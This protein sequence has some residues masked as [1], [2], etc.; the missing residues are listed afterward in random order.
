MIRVLYAD[1]EP[2]LLE[3]TRL[4]LERTGEFSVDAVESAAEGLQRLKTGQYD[5][6]LSDYQMPG[7]DGIRFLKQIRADGNTIPFIVFTGRGREDVVIDAI[8]SGA[9]SYIQK[10]G[11]P[12][13]QFAELAHKI[14]Q[15]VRRYQAERKV[16]EGAARFQA[17]FE[18]IWDIIQIFGRDGR[19]LYNSPSIYRLL[20]YPKGEPVYFHAKDALT[21]ICPDDQK[22]V[23]SRYKEVGA[24]P[25]SSQ[26]TE[27]RMKT[28]GGNYLWLES[29]FTNK[30]DVDGVRGLIVT[31]RP[32]TERKRAEEELKQKHEELNAAFEQLT[33]TEEELRQNYNELAGSERRLAS[34][35]RLVRASE[36]YLKCIINDAR[37]GI[38]AYDT[39]LKFTLW[40]PYME[41]LTG[42]PGSE[43]VGKQLGERFPWFKE[44]MHPENLKK[45]LA[46]ETRESDDIPVELS[47]KK[48]KVWIRC[49]ASPLSDHE[50]NR[51][52]V[53]GIVQDITQRKEAELALV[54]AT[55]ALKASEEKYRTSL[56][57][58]NTPLVL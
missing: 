4:Y 28:A 29:V 7:M 5:V 53:I 48:K 54:A 30:Y 11:N 38:T 37:E 56:K 9:D 46:G 24:V 55:D 39:D 21:Y 18:N 50:G 12:Q 31:S 26:Y 36:A 27:Y 22:R 3:I 33:A 42:I 40:N 15:I 14:T 41:K 49:I 1:D 8:N 16:R 10:G 13:A 20:G 47:A 6:I 57:P 43:V 32:T 34:S 25:G 52:G 44:T 51:T 2:T 35:E 19:V 58:R 45:V 17:L 23:V